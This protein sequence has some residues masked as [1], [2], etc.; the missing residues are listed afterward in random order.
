[1]KKNSLKVSAYALIVFLIFF[2]ITPVHPFQP[3]KWS[4]TDSLVTDHEKKIKKPEK[5]QVLDKKENI[6]Q[7]ASYSYK[8][9][10]LLRSE[11]YLDGEGKPEGK[12]VYHY[13]GSGKLISEELHDSSSKILSRRVYRYDSGRLIQTIAFDDR[14]EEIL[15]QSY[16][17][18]GSKII[19][20]TEVTGSDRTA[21]RID[22]DGDLL[23]SIVI[24]DES[25]SVL[26]EVT[27]LYD[28]NNRLKQRVRR[29]ANLHSIC[30]YE[31]E[32]SHL[33]SYTYYNR[34]QKGWVFDKKIELL[35]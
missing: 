4:H 10:G 33:K 16:T 14:G 1:M 23:K 12:T 15:R 32:G 27:Y 20:G 30:K 6:I 17:Y 9:N 18:Q 2:L 29:Q 28:S 21:F 31:Y 34:G 8:S 26:S 25:G 24:T 13:D 35:Y 3:G 11:T 19:G 7:R 5:I 22:Y